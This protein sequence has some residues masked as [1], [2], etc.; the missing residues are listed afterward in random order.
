MFLFSL[1]LASPFSLSLSLSLSL[2]I[3][4]Y[5]YI[6]L[7][8]SLLYFLSSFLFLI[9]ISGSCFLFCFV[10]F[11]FQDVILFLFFCLLSSFVLNQNIISFTFA[12]CFF[13]VVVF[14]F[15]FCCFGVC[16]FFEFWLPIKKHLSKK[17]KFE[18][19]KMKNAEKTD[20]LTRTVCTGVF[21]NSVLFFLFVFL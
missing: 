19:P 21:T 12:S 13:V 14:V 5:I 20:I 8:L 10:C 9:S 4:I 15:C 2:S 1:F 11:L 17:W 6:Y 16:Y 18:N 3:Y 7:S